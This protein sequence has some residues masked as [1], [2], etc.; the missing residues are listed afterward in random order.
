MS[1]KDVAQF[2][3][4]ELMEYMKDLERREEKIKSYESALAKREQDILMLAQKKQCE[5]LAALNEEKARA[6]VLQQKLEFEIKLREQ[7]Q[8]ENQLLDHSLT[9]RTL[10]DGVVITNNK[11]VES[12]L[13]KGENSDNRETST[14]P[15]ETRTNIF[16]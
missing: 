16:E 14:I 7:T 9:H 10:D 13:I 15:P 6:D 4:D 3:P 8:N 11:R 1:R 2:T 12:S 5:A